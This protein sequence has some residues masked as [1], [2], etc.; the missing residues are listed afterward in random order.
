MHELLIARENVQRLLNIDVPV[1][2]RDA[3]RG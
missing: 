1:R 2:E 3:E